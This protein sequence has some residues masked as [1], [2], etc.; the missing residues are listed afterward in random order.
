MTFFPDDRNG[1]DSLNLLETLETVDDDLDE[2]GVALV[3]ICDG[4]TAK[5]FGIGET[6]AI[7]YFENGIP[8]LYK[9][10]NISFIKSRFNSRQR[11]KFDVTHRILCVSN[12]Y[13]VSC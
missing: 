13:V 1:R 12:Y 10:E 5:E 11:P 4:D 7:V 8:T 6:P 9:G 2:A 3:K